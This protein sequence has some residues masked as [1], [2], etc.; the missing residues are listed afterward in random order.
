[1]DFLLPSVLIYSEFVGA[2][3]AEGSCVMALELM[4]RGSLEQLVNKHG[5]VKD[6][7]FLQSMLRHVLLGLSDLAKLHCVH[8][9]IKLANLLCNAQGTVKISDFGLLRQLDGTQD[10][11]NTFLGTMAFLSPERITGDQYTTK[12]DI[13]SVGISVIFLVKGRLSMPTEYWSLLSV[14]NNAAPELTAEDGASELLIDFVKK[15]LQKEPSE[16]WSADQLLA[17][18]FMTS[19]LPHNPIHPPWPVTEWVEPDAD[20]LSMIVEAVVGAYYPSSAPFLHSAEDDE[21]FLKLSEQLGC[22]PAIVTEASEEAEA[23]CPS[24]TFPLHL[25]HPAIRP[26]LPPSFHYCDDDGR[27]S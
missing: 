15:M 23:I 1:M 19:E 13:W 3:F 2:C 7:A 26:A 6:E 10:M 25:L 24:F 11:C 17:H 8:R 22:D 18:P 20:E 5:P 9:D 12:S 4:N 21:R 27:G 16:R 14:V